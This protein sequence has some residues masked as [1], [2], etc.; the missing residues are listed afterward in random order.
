MGPVHLFSLA[1]QQASWLSLR[2]TAISQNVAN[3]DTP[4][5]RAVDV[6]PFNDVLDKTSLELAS[7][8]SNHLEVPDLDLKAAKVRKSGAWEI[9][10]S[11]NSVSLEQEMMKAGEINGSFNLNRS[12]VAAFGRMLSSAVKG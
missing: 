5:Y 4:K 6:Q 10:H 8:N 12:I 2:Q 3:A 11:G 9:T 7:T 1:S